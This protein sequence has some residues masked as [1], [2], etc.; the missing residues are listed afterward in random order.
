MEKRANKDFKRFL[1]ERGLTTAFTKFQH[2]RGKKKEILTTLVNRFGVE[3]TESKIYVIKEGK[4]T[5]F[6]DFNTLERLSRSR[7]NVK[8]AIKS[9]FMQP[10]IKEREIKP[11][12]G[13]RQE[14]T[15]SKTKSYSGIL[16]YTEAKP[17]RAITLKFT[18]RVYSYFAP[19]KKLRIKTLTTSYM[20]KPKHGMVV[21]DVEY[22]KFP[23]QRHRGIYRSAGGFILNNRSE[24]DKAT[25]S[26]IHNGLGSGNVNFSPDNIILHDFWFEYYQDKFGVELTPAG[27]LPRGSR[28]LQTRT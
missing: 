25:L 22:R 13:Q 21:V 24:I 10:I 9:L 26:A 14:L 23:N 2:V 8:D 11:T 1:R 18:D 20:R 16:K 6:R 17:K 19:D 28:R 12:L 15:N 7:R 27:E 3:R 4:Y 5:V